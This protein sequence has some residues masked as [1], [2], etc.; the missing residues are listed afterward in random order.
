MKILHLED[1]PVDAELVSHFLHE[2]WPACQI[3]VVADRPHFL[4]ALHEGPHDL[5]LSDF[6]MTAFSGW[7]G[8]RLSREYEPETPFIFFSGTIR[9]EVALDAVREGAADYVLKDRPMRLI[10]SIRLALAKR[11]EAGRRLRAENLIREQNDLLDKASDA[12]VVSD[13]EGRIIFWNQ[14]ASRM[15]GWGFDE[16]AGRPS[17]EIMGVNPLAVNFTQGEWRGEVTVRSKA[18][19]L[20]CLQTHMTAVAD[21]E[22]VPRGCVSISTDVTEQNRLKEQFFRAQ[23]LESLGLLAAGIAHDL[24]NMLAP[25]LM[26][27]TILRQ[28]ATDA[29]DL[30]IIEVMEKSAQRGT[31]LVKQILAFAQGSSTQRLAIQLQPALRDMATFVQQTFPRKITLEVSIPPDLDRV[32]ASAT[33]IHQV[34]LNLCVNA[35]DAM[36]EGG[37]LIL[38]AENRNYDEEQAAKIPGARPGR[39]VVV[40]VEDT[41]PGI[42]AEVVNRIWEP[43]FTTKGLEKGTGLG[44]S[45]VRGIVQN[46]GGFIHL[47]TAVGQGTCF[48]VHLPALAPAR[49]PDA[50]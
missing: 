19:Q 33:Q 18:G 29:T 27:P 6:S 45:T 5:I 11:E 12:I 14:G 3:K 15:L 7:E 23:R 21:A 10:T 47:K 26:A 16:V 43:F 41:G 4:S 44:L 1:S 38:R 31:H 39:W 17:D 40:Q 30:K 34:L 9:E 32:M 35:R 37:R 28:R 48:S 42:A 24:N 46:H 20:L 50:A 2:E 36:A 25:I 49:E 22:G 8:F 13:L